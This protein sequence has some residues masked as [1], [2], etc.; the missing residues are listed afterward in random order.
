MKVLLMKNRVLI[1]LLIFATII[2]GLF[3]FVILK[4]D[5]SIEENKRFL[6]ERV[7][8]SEIAEKRIEETPLLKERMK[9]IESMEKNLNVF[10]DKENV[11]PAIESIEKIS[12][13][14]GNK[15]KIEIVED[16]SKKKDDSKKGDSKKS[17]NSI[18]A[19]LPGKSYLLLRMNV[20]CSFATLNAFMNK[21]ENS[22]YFSDIVSLS[23]IKKEK[24]AEEPKVSSF[25]KPKNF[26]ESNERISKAASLQEKKDPVGFENPLQAVIDAVF[27]FQ[28]E[29]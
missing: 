21:L 5:R 17:E 23:I 8:D 18:M 29:K 9:E 2:A 1:S 4:L 26:I 12:E 25:E 16:V 11:L 6:E 27:Y 10:V 13:E 15:V 28:E 14:T 7:I 19:N 20:E 22:S 24:Q 3:Q